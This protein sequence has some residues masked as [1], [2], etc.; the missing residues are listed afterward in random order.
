VDF[1]GSVSYEL[2]AAKFAADGMGIT[3][4]SSKMD[5]AFLT[6]AAIVM[7][8]GCIPWVLFAALLADKMEKVNAFMSG[9]N[10]A[11]VPVLGGGAVIGCFGSMTADSMYPLGPGTC[12][13]LASGLLMAALTIFNQKAGLQWLREWGLTICMIAGMTTA[14]A[15]Q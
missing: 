2:T 14:V 5:A 8:C 1:I 9:G 3:L 10:A 13:A 7:T 15:V 6:A 4:G 12:A 11:L